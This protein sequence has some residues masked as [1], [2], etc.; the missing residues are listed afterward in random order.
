MSADEIEPR[1]AADRLM[2]GSDLGGWQWA[3]QSNAVRALV[4]E[5]A[6]WGAGFQATADPGTIAVKLIREPFDE[7]TDPPE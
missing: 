3:A 2:W 1:L 6:Q 7:V 4:A 5:L